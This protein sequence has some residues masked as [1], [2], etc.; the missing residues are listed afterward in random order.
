MGC[1]VGECTC[2]YSLMA[3][4]KSPLLKWSFP[5]TCATFESSGALSL[6][7]TTLDELKKLAREDL[8]LRNT[9]ESLIHVPN[10]RTLDTPP[11]LYHEVSALFANTALQHHATTVKP[12]EKS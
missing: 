6:A 3:G 5:R 11:A 7:Q 2:V 4:K 9:S 8:L 12:Q 1:R 10:W